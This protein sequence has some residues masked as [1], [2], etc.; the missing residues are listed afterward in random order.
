MAQRKSLNLLPQIFQTGV[1]DKF[2]SATIDQLISE[3]KLKKIK[4]YI[5]RKLSPNYKSTDSYIEE[6]SADR[7]NYQLEPSIIV[8][9]SISNSI[10]FATTYN[11]IINKINNFKIEINIINFIF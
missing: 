6:N 3:P 5:G 1:N 2:L 11:D 7:Q 9:N 8:K 4:G 10:D